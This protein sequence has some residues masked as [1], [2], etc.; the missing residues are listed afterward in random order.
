MIEQ[1]DTWSFVILFFFGFV[2]DAEDLA[3]LSVDDEDAHDANEDISGSSLS[4]IP[5]A[6]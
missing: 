2:G 4:N 6:S 1:H 5:N 3:E